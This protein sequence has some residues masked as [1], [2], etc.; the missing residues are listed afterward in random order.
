MEI[1][2]FSPSATDAK[3][4]S[5][6]AGVIALVTSPRN[7]PFGPVTLQEITVAQLREKRLCTSSIKTGTA[8]DPDLK[9]L[10]KALS[11]ILMSGTGQASDEL[12][13]IPSESNTLTPATSEYPPTLALS[14]ACH[15]RVAARPLRLSGEAIPAN[16][17]CAATSF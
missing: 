9:A 8:A 11:A 3:N 13:S 4:F 15:S 1:L 7:S 2:A 5:K 6:C 12:I 16:P 14:I 17:I 10:K